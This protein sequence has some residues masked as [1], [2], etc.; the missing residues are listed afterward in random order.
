ME[1]KEEGVSWSALCWAYFGLHSSWWALWAASMS[2]GN[3]WG[4]DGSCAS[5]W[6]SPQAQKC[7]DI[8]KLFSS[9]VLCWASW[10]ARD[11]TWHWCPSWSLPARASTPRHIQPICTHR[12]GPMCVRELFLQ[13]G[14]QQI[15]MG[16]SS[17]NNCWDKTKLVGRKFRPTKLGFQT[18]KSVIAV[19]L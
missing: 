15:H 16:V 11:K 7:K 19:L 18:W 10:E 12:I 6:I 9:L 5:P 17:W 3:A 14:P 1:G 4:D 2:Y 13:P 8:M